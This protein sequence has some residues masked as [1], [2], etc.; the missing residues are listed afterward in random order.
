MTMEIVWIQN[1]KALIEHGMFR[2]D[3]DWKKIFI[4]EL[5]RL[6]EEQLL[7]QRPSSEAAGDTPEDVLTAAIMKAANEC[8]A[9]F[10]WNNDNRWHQFVANSL[11]SE[12]NRCI[13]IAQSI[14][15]HNEAEAHL[16]ETIVRRMRGEE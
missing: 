13:S 8:V 11:L 16:I 10:R 12:R 4:E 7:K 9:Q 2:T 14:V 15:P 3:D 6:N 5:D 1:L